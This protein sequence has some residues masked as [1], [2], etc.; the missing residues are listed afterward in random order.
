MS[1]TP[2]I[3]CIGPSLLGYMPTKIRSYEEMPIFLYDA[4]SCLLE[5]A[6]D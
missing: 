4:R 5:E 6:E 1:E 3:F 2:I